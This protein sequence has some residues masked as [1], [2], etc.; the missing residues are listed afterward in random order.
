MKNQHGIGF[1]A[2]IA[3]LIGAL[4]VASLAMQPAVAKT[5][6]A[7]ARA[8][9]SGR[10]LSFEPNVGQGAA[11]GQYFAHGPAYAIA[12]SEQ[13]AA[14]ASELSVLR[15]RIVG[16]REGVKPSAEQPLSGVVN[17]FIGNDPKQW[18]A[19]IKTYGKVRYSGVYPGVDLIYYGT[20]GRL[21]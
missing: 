8:V 1:C 13:G 14:L 4:V 15:L 12:L 6:A 20:Q 10:P 19:G 16:S 17:Y 9:I 7:P 3:G 5:T 2:Q 21:E 18:R 11:D